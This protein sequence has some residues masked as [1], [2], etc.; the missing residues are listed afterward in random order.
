MLFISGHQRTIQQLPICNLGQKL[1]SRADSIANEC[2]TL[3]I[4]RLW[5]VI[6]T[7]L[8]LPLLLVER[9]RR[10]NETGRHSVQSVP[11]A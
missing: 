6:C 7:R 3:T 8:S 11:V 2:S 5:R 9:P 10:L 1:L 4:V